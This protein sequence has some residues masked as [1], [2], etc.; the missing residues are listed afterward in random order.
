[1]LRTGTEGDG[2]RGMGMAKLGHSSM[3]LLRTVHASNRPRTS[4]AN[5]PSH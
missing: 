2:I 1:M 3:L 5:S 4:I